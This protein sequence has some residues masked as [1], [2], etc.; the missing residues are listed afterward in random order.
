M[1]HYR[2]ITL[3][4]PLADETAQPIQNALVSLNGSIRV[5]AETLA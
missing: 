1:V 2:L 5:A 4:G 3:V